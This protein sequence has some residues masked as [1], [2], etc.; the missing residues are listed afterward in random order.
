[1]S[2][3]TKWFVAIVFVMLGAAISSVLIARSMRSSFSSVA[4]T[5]TSQQLPSTSTTPSE[6]P[7]DH[8]VSATTTTLSV[9]GKLAPFRR[10]A[11][12][13]S[14]PQKPP[15]VWID[16]GKTT[17]D[18]PDESYIYRY[19]YDPKSDSDVDSHGEYVYSKSTEGASYFSLE[20]YSDY[21]D[22]TIER[23]IKR[24]YPDLNLNTATPFHKGKFAGFLLSYPGS[25][26]SDGGQILMFKTGHDV[27][28]LTNESRMFSEME[29]TQ[30]VNSITPTVAESK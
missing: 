23:Y 16:Q 8:N 19:P 7:N 13:F 12:S 9:S 2:R 5:A 22:E 30:I 15:A 28:K 26:G 4:D 24:N 25:P 17:D 6:Q 29:F 18:G 27:F 20:I 14:Y 3:Q 11:L 10:S 21:L 1:M